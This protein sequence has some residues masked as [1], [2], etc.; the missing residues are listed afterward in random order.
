[1]RIAVPLMMIQHTQYGV[2]NNHYYLCDHFKEIFEELGITLFP[3]FPVFSEENVREIESVC[4]GLILSGSNKNI[5]PEYYGQERMPE[6][7]NTYT[8]DE[9]AKDVMLLKAFVKSGKP[10]L[11]ICGG[12][13][14]LNVYFGGTLKQFVPDH[15]GVETNHMLHIEKDSFLY[16]VYN[17]D[18]ISGNSYHL[19]CSDVPAPGFRV[20]ARAEDG[21]VEGIEKDNII[22]V[23]W[24]PEAMR[25]MTFFKK[26]VEK[27]LTK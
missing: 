20:T 22:G 4:D 21:T 5:Y 9:Y 7:A 26:Y 2:W 17:T 10:V 3:V 6:M 11:G 12:I 13:Q 1:M 24:H 23:Q 16:E 8:V 27:Y 14:T 19:Q 18:T 25:D 15:N